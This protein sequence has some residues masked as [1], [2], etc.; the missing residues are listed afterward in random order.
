MEGNGEQAIAEKGE[1]GLPSYLLVIG[2]E[3]ERI[4][5]FTLIYT[6]TIIILY[7]QF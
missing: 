4:N 6:N 5:E 1:W 7:F 3:V 2:D